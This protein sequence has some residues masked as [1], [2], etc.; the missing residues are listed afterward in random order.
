MIDL[1]SPN[2]IIDFK[3]I[4]YKN[5]AAYDGRKKNANDTDW[6]AVS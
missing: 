5:K 1:F 6:H 2:I 3:D 4:I